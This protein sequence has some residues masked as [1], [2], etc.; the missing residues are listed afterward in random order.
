M[1]LYR[2]SSVVPFSEPKKWDSG[3]APTSEMDNPDERFRVLLKAV[4]C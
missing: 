4:V 3:G 1:N 2:R